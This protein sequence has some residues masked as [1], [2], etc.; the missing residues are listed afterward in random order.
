MT[1][2]VAL[3]FATPVSV[4]AATEDYPA[5]YLPTVEVKINVGNTTLDDA[6]FLLDLIQAL[7]TKGIALSKI[8]VGY[9]G[10][11]DNTFPVT[12]PTQWTTYDHF[13]EW[14][15]IGGI[16]DFYDDVLGG[17]AAAHDPNWTSDYYVDDYDFDG[18][19]FTFTIYYCD[20][21]SGDCFETDYVISTLQDVDG[22]I[23]A[24]LLDYDANGT[25]TSIYDDA[26]ALIES[27]PGY[28]GMNYFNGM[29]YDAAKGKSYVSYYDLN[30]N[31]FELEFPAMATYLGTENLLSGFTIVGFDYETET[32][33]FEYSNGTDSFS[34]AFPAQYWGGKEASHY[35][36][37]DENPDG[38]DPVDWTNDPHIVTHDDGSVTFY[39]YGSPAYK[40]FM[41]SKDNTVSDKSFKFDL[42]GS[43]VDYHSMEGGGFLF[44]IA[45]NDQSTSDAADDTMSGYAVLFT[46]GGTN[47]YQLTDVNIADFHDESGNAMEY[48]NGVSLLDTYAKD[49]STEQ[50]YIQIDIVNNVLTVRDNE[51]MA[52]DG[53]PLDVV[54]NRF[55]PLVSYESHGCEQLSW[56]VYDNLK[57][58]STIKVVSKAQDNVGTIEWLTGAYPVY[59]NLEDTND[60]TLDVT[61][62]ADELKADGVDYIG[63]GLVASKPMHD[64]IV[65]ANGKG[66]YVELPETVDSEALAQAIADYLWPLLEPKTIDNIRNADLDEEVLSTLPVK[67]VVTIP[68]GV[69]DAFDDLAA[70]DD[71]TIELNIN[72]VETSAVSETDRQLIAA[73]LNT[74]ANHDKMSVYYLDIDL[75]KVINGTDK[76]V[77]TETL[78]PITITITLPEALWAMTEF[79]VLRIHDGVVSKLDLIVD[80]VNHTVTFTTD[81][82]STYGIQ[83]TNPNQLPDTGVA[84]DASAVLLFVGAGLWLISR[85]KKQ[86]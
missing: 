44:S 69:I 85:N 72:V 50:H 76:T 67:P 15:E 64:G 7:K 56:F 17:Y 49:D 74:L 59:I 52:I 47:L 42:D 37:P 24:N 45:V 2:A 4:S 43:A 35:P 81:K 23:R 65:A 61:D 13:G 55:G 12:D 40:D 19:T 16:V 68:D 11:I 6:Q 77:V 73:Y 8:D 36:A 28:A 80:A 79:S 39:G 18:S 83:Y 54:G 5:K 58:G 84:G 38:D 70:G 9:A 22:L 41:L 25:I 29:W 26:L 31:Y 33:S 21:D 14:G 32:G 60:A 46:Q 10:S 62:F 51:V 78:K 86:A 3:V 63:A 53:Y 1:L 20:D 48:V 34:V 66:L 75:F 30:W 71:V 57:M 27:Q 82:F